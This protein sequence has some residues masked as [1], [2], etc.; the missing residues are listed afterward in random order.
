[1]TIKN[2][3]N[4]LYELHCHLYGCLKEEDLQW[5]GQRKTPRWEIFKNSYKTLYQ[6]EPDLEILYKNKIFSNSILNEVQKNILR[7]FYIMEKTD[8]NSFLVFQ[9]KFDFIISLSHTDPEELQELTKR[10]LY[11]QKEFYSEYR[12]MFSPKIT[13][14]EFKEK[15]K[16]LV[17]SFDYM[18]KE[19]VPKKAKLIISLNREYPLYEWQYE[20]IKEIKKNSNSLIGIDFAGKE[21]GFPPKEKFKFVQQVHKDNQSSKPILILYHVGESFNDK[22]PASAIR[23]ILEIQENYVHRIGHAIALAYTED[24]I[25]D[26]IF[27][28][29]LE[30]RKDHLNFLI[31]L[32][33]KGENWIP[34]DYIKKEKKRIENYQNSYPVVYKDIE[35]KLY[36]DFLEYSITILKKQNVIIESCPTSNLRICGFSPLK[37]FVE[38]GLNV[39]LGADDPSIF[40]TTLEKEFEFAQ[41]ILSPKEVKKIKE[42][43]KKYSGEFLLKEIYK[44]D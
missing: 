33:E 43:N 28:E 13:Q 35:K 15:V 23:W 12:M 9:N 29:I 37:F 14:I 39:C 42:N 27:N 30:E 1:M 5:L 25:Q 41:S 36:L 18:E 20:I 26:K 17:E 6:K 31:L 34:I 19:I 44:K 10:V 21:E 16:A 2:K 11:R 32:Y 8:S 24:K 3:M 38:K 4:D 7:K 22:T 40:D